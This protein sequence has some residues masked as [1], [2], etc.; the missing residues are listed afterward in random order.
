[1]NK[2]VSTQQI[3]IRYVSIIMCEYCS[4]GVNGNVMHRKYETQIPSKDI[5]CT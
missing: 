4:Y 5:E 3:Y 1:M 2:H